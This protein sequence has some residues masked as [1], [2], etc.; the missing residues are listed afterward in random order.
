MRGAGRT[1]D[2]DG[3]E[4]WFSEAARI[5]WSYGFIAKRDSAGCRDKL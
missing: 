1:R 3:R 5:G 2:S 4:R